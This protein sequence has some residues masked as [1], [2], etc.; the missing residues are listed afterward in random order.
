[1]H[2]PSNVRAPSDPGRRSPAPLVSPVYGLID[3]DYASTPLR[4]F[5]RVR[6]SRI[7]LVLPA[8]V[9]ERLVGIGHL[10]HVFALLDRVAAALRC[11][12]QLGGEAFDHG[13][14]ATL[15]AVQHE[16][17]HGKRN[18]TIGANFDRNLVGRTTDAAAL[19][20]DLRLDGI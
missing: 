2:A 5:P 15:A 20:L 7:R 16:P 18:T 8:V 1:S 10:V 9:G 19:D 17:A 3:I 12:L 13:L 4:R 14:L 11:F 6:T